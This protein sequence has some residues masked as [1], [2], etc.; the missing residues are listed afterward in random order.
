M[1]HELETMV[2]NLIVALSKKDIS[3][4]PLLEVYRHHM[5]LT[6]DQDDQLHGLFENLDFDN[7]D[8]IDLLMCSGAEFVKLHDNFYG[9]RLNQFSPDNQEAVYWINTKDNVRGKPMS[10]LYDTVKTFL[11]A[12]PEEKRAN[13][14][15]VLGECGGLVKWEVVQRHIANNPR[16]AAFG[17]LNHPNRFFTPSPDIYVKI[18]DA[19][20][21]LVVPSLDYISLTDIHAEEPTWFTVGKTV[22]NSLVL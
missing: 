17:C 12:I 11:D 18:R 5:R 2:G 20:G 16:N 22:R 8:L 21:E 10:D 6:V 14:R 1:I 3:K 13:Q 7:T 4:Y 9:L 15:I 19:K